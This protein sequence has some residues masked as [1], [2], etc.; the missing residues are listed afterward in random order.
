MRKLQ[1]ERM[2][3]I[4]ELIELIGNVDRG[5][6][7]SENGRG[8]FIE[9]KT[10][11]KFIDD[12]TQKELTI[13]G[14]GKRIKGFSSGGTLQGLV[15]DFKHYIITGKPSDGKHGYGGL[16]CTHW[17]YSL[18]G[19][20]KIIEFAKEIGYIHPKKLSFKDYTYKLYKN[21]NWAL[22]MTLRDE[23]KNIYGEI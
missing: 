7:K 12:Y 20:N 22:G 16:Y 18:E 13:P 1:V 15:R 8:K 19:Q 3:K 14:E 6:F 10:T 11:V 2:N 9:K 17:G 23:L 5:F 21:N 4:N